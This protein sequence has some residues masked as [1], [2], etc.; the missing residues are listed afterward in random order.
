MADSTS[1]LADS[2]RTVETFRAIQNDKPECKARSSPRRVIMQSK[3]LPFALLSALGLGLATSAASAAQ[4][5]CQMDFTLS[6][7]SIIYQTANGAGTVTRSEER[8][9]G[10]GGR[11]R[12][13]T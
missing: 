1:A 4:I 10:K 13:G 6:G 7:W 3:A 8:R 2:S 5:K 9:V 11:T 12:V